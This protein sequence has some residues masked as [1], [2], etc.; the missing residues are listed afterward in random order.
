MN[1][2]GKTVRHVKFGVGVV[3]SI[4]NSLITI[5]FKE[6]EKSFLYPFVFKSYLVFEDPILQEYINEQIGQEENAI[7]RHQRTEHKALQQRIGL[8]AFQPSPDSHFAINVASDHAEHV[9]ETLAVSTGVYLKGSLKGLPRVITKARPNSLCF[10]TTRNHEQ[11]ESK[12]LLIGAF[13]VAEDFF[14]NEVSDG[15][16]RGHPKYHFILPENL[17][18]PFWD[19]LDCPVPKGWGRIAYK[20]VSDA[21]ANRI[22]SEM[23]KIIIA[24]DHTHSA[25]DFYQ[26]FCSVNQLRS[27][28]DRI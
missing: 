14:G 12:R 17:R 4:I 16:V 5:R 21:T 10:I 9:F 11:D 25:R 7:Q 2:I 8:F 22:L 6:S 28:L 27:R 19:Q 24:I 23:V 13:M 1:P 15:I 20:H 3:S 26:Y 18:L